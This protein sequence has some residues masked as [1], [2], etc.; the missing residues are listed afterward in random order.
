MNRRLR[1]CGLSIVLSTFVMAA[2]SGT[3]PSTATT[4]KQAAR[5]T[6]TIGPRVE[7]KKTEL[8]AGEVD[9]SVPSESRFPVRNT[10]GEPL[11][12][13][14]VGKSCF[15][16]DAV[17]P[18]EPLAPGQEGAV[19]VRWTPIPGKS[20]QQRVHVDLET[21]DPT[22]PTV[23]LAVTGV[24]NP[25]I[26][27]APEDASYIDFY[28]LEPGAVKPRELKVFSTKL[29][30]SDLDAKVD[31]PAL[32]VT[33][34]KLELDA[35]SR[36]GDARPTCAYSV[37]IETTPQLP[38]GSFTTDLVLTLRPPGLPPREVRM[39]IY[40]VVANGIFKVLPDE[41]EFKTPRLADGDARKVRVQFVDP[42]KKQTLK[43]VRVDPTFVQCDEPRLLHGAPGQWEFT[44][45]IPASNTEA[46]KLQ[47][48]G[49]F[50]GQVVLQASGTNAQIPVRVKWNPPEP[51]EKH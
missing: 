46:A 15:C 30:K 17:V 45:R 19:H 31:S 12:L 26:R 49:F 23:R 39:R 3:T 7:I 34:N 20:G 6:P 10:G 22:R 9:F 32:V 13:T 1:S 24:V 48:D 21:N 37:L 50:E 29:S 41:I 8:D 16:T 14:L 44:A 38:P 5:P 25:L 2:C 35:N 36:I 4:A 47:A 40:G 33:M 42:S 18:A 11:L 43:I 28:R 27:I 51:S